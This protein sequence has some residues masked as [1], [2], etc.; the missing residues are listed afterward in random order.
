MYN[1]TATNLRKNLF[2]MLNQTIKYNEP[3]TVTTKS[4]NAV[5]LS[6]ED[7]NALK[8]TLYLTSI[9]GMEKKLIDAMNEDASTCIDAN[10]VEW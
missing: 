8:E 1:T 9:P 2:G 7:Y 4:G 5:I 6:E 10:E 3:V